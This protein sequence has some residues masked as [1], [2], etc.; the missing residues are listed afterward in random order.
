MIKRASTSL[1]ATVIDCFCIHLFSICLFHVASKPKTVVN[2][3]IMKSF[4]DVF[5]IKFYFC[6]LQFK[7]KFANLNKAIVQCLI[8]SFRLQISLSV[9]EKKSDARGAFD[10]SENRCC[11][12]FVRLLVARIN[13]FV[14]C[15]EK[16]TIERK[17]QTLNH[18]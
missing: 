18:V 16:R 6:R 5:K 13:V 14:E 7:A 4:V 3:I 11:D 1:L 17:I 12:E 2:K 10:R 9:C 8:S 15:R